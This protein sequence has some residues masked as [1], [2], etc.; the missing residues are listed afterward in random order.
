M[1]VHGRV[2]ALSRPR[3]AAA[4][5]RALLGTTRK[6]RILLVARATSRKIAQSWWTKEKR[7]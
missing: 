7:R 6:I 2:H 4:A 1:I 3:R 5:A